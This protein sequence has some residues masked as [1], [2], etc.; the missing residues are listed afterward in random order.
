MNVENTHYL[1]KLHRINFSALDPYNHV[2]TVVYSAYYD[3][4]R[5]NMKTL[6][7]VPFMVWVANRVF[8]IIIT[9]PPLH[10]NPHTD[11]VGGCLDPALHPAGDKD[12]LPMMAARTTDAPAPTS[13]V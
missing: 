10:L 5:M 11:P 8:N 4:L 2:R 12:E 9:L 6:A 1:Q 7:M 3:D 13:T